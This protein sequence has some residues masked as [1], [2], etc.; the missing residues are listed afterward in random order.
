[1]VAFSVDSNV[2]ALIKIENLEITSSIQ[3]Q[4]TIKMEKKN[5]QT[6]KHLWKTIDQLKLSIAQFKMTHKKT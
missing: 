1:M 5:S 6:L 4:S 3:I 2:P